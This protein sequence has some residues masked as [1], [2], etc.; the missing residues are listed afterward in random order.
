[1]RTLIVG[2][3]HGCKDE[4][5][6]LVE[7][8][9]FVP[10]RDRLLQT[11]DMISRGPD[12]LGALE[13]ARD[14]GMRSVMG[15]HE[16]RLLRI[17]AERP[18]DRVWKDK[19]FLERLGDDAVQIAAMVRDWPLWIE[20]EQFFLVHAGFQPGV[21]H[22][23]FMDARVLLH[24]RTW[25]GEG[26]DMDN[27]DNPPWFQCD[28]WSKTIVFGHWANVGLVQRPGLRGLD[29]GCAVG[30]ALTGWCPEENRIYQVKSNQG[31]TVQCL[32]QASA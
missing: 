12:S 5:E 18:M 26:V 19:M 21:S 24:V 23:V 25:D 32:Q 17:L 31:N 14:L 16:A 13:L 7:R 29:T 20:D 27:E 4:L 22:P 8:F 11:G 1:M 9:G 3:V 30:G 6:A 10:G 28:A 15:N 2:D